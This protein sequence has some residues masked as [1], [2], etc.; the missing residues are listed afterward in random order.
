MRCLACGAEMQLIE[1]EAVPDETMMV[2]SYEHHTFE[3]SGCHNHVRQLVF[4]REIGPLPSERMRLPPAR[5][6]T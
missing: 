4:T 2:P 6:K 5:L 3:C 1:V